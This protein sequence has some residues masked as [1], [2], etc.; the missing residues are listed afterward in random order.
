MYHWTKYKEKCQ[1]ENKQID[2]R[3]RRKFYRAM[4]MI[5]KFPSKYPAKISSDYI[6][7]FCDGACL[8]TETK[9]FIKF[10]IG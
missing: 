5:K 3:V 8:D 7:G 4:D 6:D 9:E 10:I 1:K 2:N